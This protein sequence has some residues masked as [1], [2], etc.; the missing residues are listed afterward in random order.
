MTLAQI[1]G[2][3][4]TIEARIRAAEQV[5]ADHVAMLELLRKSLQDQCPHEWAQGR[6]RGCGKREPGE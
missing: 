5:Y 6:C 2:L 4:G 1:A 3:I